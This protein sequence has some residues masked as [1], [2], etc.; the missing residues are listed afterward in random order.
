M[1]KEKFG[2]EMDWFDRIGIDKTCQLV[3][4]HSGMINLTRTDDGTH[5]LWIYDCP[6]ASGDAVTMRNR[7]ADMIKGDILEKYYRS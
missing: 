5:T 6:I 1:A 2:P 4:A 7:Y 3:A